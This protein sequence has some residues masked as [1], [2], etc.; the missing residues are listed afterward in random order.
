MRI[1]FWQGFPQSSVGLF[2]SRAFLRA[3]TLSDLVATTRCRANLNHDRFGFKAQTQAVGGFI[4]CS[5]AKPIAQ[6]SA[7]WS[8]PYLGAL[9][10][11]RPTK[12]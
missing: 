6:M 12:R 2:F 1:R 3:T 7:H 11:V 4:R 9:G 10:P 5:V 8:I